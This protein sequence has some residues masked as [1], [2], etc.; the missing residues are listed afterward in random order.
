MENLQVGG[1]CRD[2]R[3]VCACLHLKSFS[4]LVLRQS[5]RRGPFADDKQ[6]T[7][8]HEGVFLLGCIAVMMHVDTWSM[9]TELL[10]RMNGRSV[11]KEWLSLLIRIWLAL[12]SGG[13]P[14]NHSSSQT[15]QAMYL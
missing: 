10:C 7:T 12:A 9:R 14:R 13:R 11:L 4:I 8:T 3:E 6:A 5:T 1:P 2:L 15:S